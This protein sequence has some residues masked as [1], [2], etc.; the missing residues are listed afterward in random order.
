MATDIAFFL[1]LSL[2]LGIKH[3]Y[4]ADHLV[5][6]S[7]F[8][9]RSKSMRDT[10]KMTISW[11][12]GHMLT[13]GVITM[14][15][16]T[17]AVRAGSISGI[18]EHFE[19][20]V[21]VMLILIGLIGILLEVPIVHRHVH[22]HTMK[23]KTHTHKHS[24]RFGGLGRF[25]RKA[26]IH[27]PLFSVGI[28]HGLASNDELLA[29]FAAGLGIGSIWMLII[30]LVVFTAGV[31]SGMMAFGAIITYPVA[32]RKMDRIK[33]AITLVAGLLSIAYGFMMLAGM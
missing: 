30:G 5:A 17:A 26:H 24:H 11:A 8:L 14:L 15:L 12:L 32:K 10:A 33:L 7:N 19:S 6:V 20:V 23:A 4:D 9:A 18:L 3:A 28:I 27:P 2:A 21:A 13:A 22:R 31:M 1:V 16:F 25:A 29:L